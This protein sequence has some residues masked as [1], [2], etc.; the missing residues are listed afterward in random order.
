MIEEIKLFA[1][2]CISSLPVGSIYCLLAL[3]YV[4]IFKATRLLNLCQGEIMM[5][6]AYFCYSATQLKLSLISA[7]ILSI[8]LTSFVAFLL[9]RFLLRKIMG[10][11]DFVSIMVVI[12]IGILFRGIV[13][14]VWGVG[15]KEMSVPYFDKMV[16]LPGLHMNYGK[17]SVILIAIMSIIILELFFKLTKIGMAMK[18]T[19]SN[20]AASMIMGVNIGHV[21]SLS[22]ILAAIISIFPGIFLAKLT[23]LNPTISLYG[24]IALSALVLGGV[25]SII[26]TIVAGYTIG[27]AEGI[28]VF[29]IGGQSKHLAGFIVMFLV[30]MIRPTGF[31]GVKKVERV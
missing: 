20:R 13:G 14:V 28:S 31:C 23:I 26:G 22:W 7:I 30:L 2:V 21:F 17:L 5:L 11:P 6:G 15:E 4:L 25:D 24:F 29:Y 16:S 19:A 3:S 9:E 1:E 10:E 8:I 12:G 27:I 18:A